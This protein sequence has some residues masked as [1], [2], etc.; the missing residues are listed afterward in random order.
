MKAEN[1]REMIT[2]MLKTID[3]KAIL[4]YI[5]LIVKDIVMRV[6]E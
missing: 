6:Y 4:R 2:V 3:D 5:Y 1:Y